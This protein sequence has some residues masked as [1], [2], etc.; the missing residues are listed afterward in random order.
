NLQLG[1]GKAINSFRQPRFVTPGCV[2]LDDALLNG[3]IND[4][5]GSRQQGFGVSRLAGGNGSSHF[6]QLSLQLMAIHLICHAPS[7]ILAM[8]FYCGW[9]V[10]HRVSF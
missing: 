6:L 10:S 4:A 5:K 3:P 8:S 2:L 7:L 1:G 9:M